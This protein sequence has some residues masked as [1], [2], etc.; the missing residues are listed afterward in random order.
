MKDTPEILEKEGPNH[1]DLKASFTEIIHHQLTTEGSIDVA[2]EKNLDRVRSDLKVLVRMVMDRETKTAVSVLAD[3]RNTGGYEGEV[4][5]LAANL[6]AKVLEVAQANMDRVQ[7]A[8]DEETDA[9][10]SGKKK[11]RKTHPATVHNT[12]QS[13]TRALSLK[14][15]SEK[16]KKTKTSKAT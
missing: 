12:L 10:T 4:A 16:K 2:I 11:K 8:K 14:I 1:W 3:K 5:M 7:R 13:I 15:S 9:A 6:A